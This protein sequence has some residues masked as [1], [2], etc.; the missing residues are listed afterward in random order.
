MP[1]LISA[2]SADRFSTYLQW[3]SGDQPLAERLYTYNV[4]LSAALYGPLHMQEVAL[5]IWRTLH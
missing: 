5:A 4:Q 1:T 2:L 3:T